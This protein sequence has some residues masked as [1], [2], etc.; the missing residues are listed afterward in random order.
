VL[1]GVVRGE[2]GGLFCWIP[3]YVPS[4]KGCSKCGRFLPFGEFRS[5]LR[6]QT[7]WDSWCRECHREAGQRWR[8]AKPEYQEAYNQRRRVEP[9]EV[10]CEECGTAFL[11]R[12]NRVV[13]SRRCKDARYR[14]LHLVEYREKERRKHA[15]RRAREKGQA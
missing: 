12:P 8:A 11:G 7:G 15:R 2:D 4:G 1:A 13:C 5:N 6:L 14:R 3:P 10:R 9:V